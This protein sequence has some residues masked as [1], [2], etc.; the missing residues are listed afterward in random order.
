[1]QISKFTPPVDPY[2]FIKPAKILFTLEVYMNHLEKP[3]F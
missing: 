2:A 1:M 3:W